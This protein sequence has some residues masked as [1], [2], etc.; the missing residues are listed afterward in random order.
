[1]DVAFA[2]LQDK[3]INEKLSGDLGLFPMESQFSTAQLT[4][5]NL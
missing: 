5:I 2:I 3:V 4:S 1:M